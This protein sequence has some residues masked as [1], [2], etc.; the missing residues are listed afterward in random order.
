MYLNDHQRTAFYESLGMN[1]RQFNQHV[2]I[3]TNKSTERLF[4]AV[5]NVETPEFW[6]KMNYLVDL[7][8]Q[9]CNIEKGTLP[10]FLKPIA[11]APFKERMIAT[12][13]QI[14]FMTPKQTGSLDLTKPT[15]YSY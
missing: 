12:M 10:S 4:P 6:D 15:Q 5:P 8:A 7:N 3:E 14:F 11:T 9:V 1:T 13:A 2:I